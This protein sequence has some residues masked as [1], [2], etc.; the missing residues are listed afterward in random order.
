MTAGGAEGQF[1]HA[2]LPPTL[3]GGPD[4]TESQL[5]VRAAVL[6]DAAVA[7]KELAELRQQYD[8]LHQTCVWL[9][10]SN[11]DR[12]PPAPSLHTGDV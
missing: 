12:N 9:Q 2:D 4:H 8:E 1:F 3:L 5:P 7:L 6:T 11:A 10:V